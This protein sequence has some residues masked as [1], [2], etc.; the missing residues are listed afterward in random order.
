MKRI[1]LLLLFLSVNT[2]GSYIPNAVTSGGSKFRVESVLFAGN[3][4]PSAVC[5]GATCT[6]ALQSSSWVSSIT[7]VSAGVYTVSIASGT[8]SATPMC[9]CSTGY[10]AV[11]S[12]SICGSG[13]SSPS[14]TSFT[15]NANSADNVVW[16][17]CMGPR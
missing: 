17:M 6:I 11:A 4:T 16:L 15:V 13:N 14:S 8:F 9:I 2:W 10:N 5:S 7:R 12:P 1:T 3:A